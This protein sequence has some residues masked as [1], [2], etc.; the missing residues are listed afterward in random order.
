M[1]KCCAKKFGEIL[2]FP[3]KILNGNEI[4]RSI[5]GNNSV[6]NLR[7]KVNNPNQDLVN[8]NVY[9]KF[10]QILSIRSV[11]EIEQKRNSDNYK[12]PLRITN[13]RILTVNNPNLALFKY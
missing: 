6:T 7:M 5:K 9:T 10:G 2:S 3:F 12:W 13:L 11:Q 8:I 4:L 1:K